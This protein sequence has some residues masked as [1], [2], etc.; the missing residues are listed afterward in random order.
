ME[1]TLLKHTLQNKIKSPSSNDLRQSKFLKFHHMLHK[2]FLDV[3]YSQEEAY[4]PKQSLE[5]RTFPTTH[6]LVQFHE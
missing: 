1:L 5:S 2:F 3:V 4:L 6:R